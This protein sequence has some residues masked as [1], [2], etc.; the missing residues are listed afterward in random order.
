MLLPFLDG[1]LGLGA[2]SLRMLGNGGHGRLILV[3]GPLCLWRL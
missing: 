3:F 2:G 1:R